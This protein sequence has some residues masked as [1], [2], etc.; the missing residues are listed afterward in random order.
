MPIDATVG[1][2]SSNSYV[3]L[4]E[5][6]DYYIN[7][8]HFTG[9]L[10]LD[11]DVKSSLLVT[12]SLQLD[13][14]I[15]WKGTKA[16][17]T[18]SMEWPRTGVVDKNVF[19][20]SDAIIPVSVKQAVFELA[21]SS[22]KSDRTADNPLAGISSIKAGS[23]AVKAEDPSFTSTAKQAIPEKVKKILTGLTV[24]SGVGVVRLQRA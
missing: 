21:L 8:S 4:Q 20:V 24:Y 18:Q 17:E 1:G 6:D 12:A 14:Y 10:A 19:D 13:W 7:R 3:T 11:E 5:A 22:V 9:W 23:L 2:T 16:T 15:K